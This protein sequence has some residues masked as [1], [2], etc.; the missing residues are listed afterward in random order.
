M[1]REHRAIF[2]GCTEDLPEKC[3]ERLQNAPGEN[4]TRDLRLERLKV[5]RLESGVAGMMR[6]EC[7]PDTVRLMLW[8]LPGEMMAS[9]W[10]AG[11][12]SD[13]R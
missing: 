6:P 4:R 1:T 8:A 13:L 2:I 7:D 11:E 12:L 10:G 3:S 9:G 5:V